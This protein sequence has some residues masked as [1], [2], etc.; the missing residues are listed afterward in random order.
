LTIL[1][2]VV[3]VVVVEEEEEEEEEEECR[4]ERSGGPRQEVSS[5]GETL[6]PRVRILLQA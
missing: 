6:G 1:V 3:V 5:P 4:S 2:V